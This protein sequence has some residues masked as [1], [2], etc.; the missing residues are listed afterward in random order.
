MLYNAKLKS[1]QKNYYD[2]NNWITPNFVNINKKKTKRL[3][4]YNKSMTIFQEEKRP[5]R[6]WKGQ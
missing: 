5:V 4:S 2:I 6:G 1:T 3:S